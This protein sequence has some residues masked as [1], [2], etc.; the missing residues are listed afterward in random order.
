MR[1]G[2]AGRGGGGIRA[3]G[4]GA[5]GDVA[6]SEIDDGGGNEKR[7]D[8]VRTLFEEIPVL[9]LDDFESADAASDDYADAFGI[10]RVHL[11]SRL[12][13]SEFRGRDAELNEA[14]HLLNFF[15]LGSRTG[16]RENSNSEDGTLHSSRDPGL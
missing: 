6:G 5:D 2:G 3:F 15:F 13:E 4:A 10:V 14:A 7:R 16:H 9:A 8:A 1:T 12:G 11:Q